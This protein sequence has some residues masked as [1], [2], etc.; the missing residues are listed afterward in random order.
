LKFFQTLQ[1]EQPVALKADELLERTE[2]EF[3]IFVPDDYLS[4]LYYSNFTDKLKK[5][6]GK[7]HITL[8]IE[9]SPKSFFF[10]EQMQWPKHTCCVVKTQN[11]P[12]F[13]VSDG[14][15]LL[16]AFHE[17]DVPN[18]AGDKKEDRTAAIWTNYNAFV[19]ALQMLFSE[20]L[21]TVK[22][23]MGNTSSSLQTIYW[24]F[25][26]WSSPVLFRA[27]FKSQ[28]E[29]LSHLLGSQEKLFAS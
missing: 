15:E 26:I 12:C 4:Q 10:M 18:E 23:V 17:G 13:M 6:L 5:K 27:C 2:K 20:L 1:G 22:K 7:L 3:Q 9:N 8:I 21:E 25:L 28:L 29:S 14:K 24:T 11:L 16:I 19:W